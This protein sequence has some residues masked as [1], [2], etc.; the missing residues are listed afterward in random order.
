MRR[1][2]QH[3]QGGRLVT[4][5]CQRRFDLGKGKTVGSIFV[6]RKTFDPGPMPLERPQAEQD[7]LFRSTN[8]DGM[9]SEAVEI[10]FE[11]PENSVAR[12]RLSG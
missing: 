3:P 1:A 11:T 6:L 9:A 12:S 4:G 2:N 8:G 10:V 7:P 5:R